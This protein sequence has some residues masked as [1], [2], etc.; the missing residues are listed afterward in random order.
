MS[1]TDRGPSQ[2]ALGAAS[3]RAAH[4]LLDGEPKIL[5]D[6]IVLKLLHPSVLEWIR[7]H[8]DYYQVP[9][10]R[11][12]RT[13][14]MVRSRF[15]EERLE[16]AARA[17]VSQYVILGAG[18]DTFA[19]RQPTWA[20]GLKVFEVDHPASQSAKQELLK[21]AGI[22]QPANLEYVPIDF[23][24]DSLLAGLSRSP[25]L[26]DRPVFFSLL[27]VIVYLT[28][29]AI[30]ALFQAIASL[31]A[32]TEI[33]FSFSSRNPHPGEP[34]RA[35]ITET[36]AA[37]GGEPWITFFQPDALEQDLRGHGFSKIF[38]LTPEETRRRYLQGRSDSLSAS[39][40]ISIVSAR[41]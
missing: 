12:L 34:H 22:P 13:H 2:T 39:P 17:G 27:G 6:P 23:E 3:L 10:R 7:Q 36:Q 29:D 32:Q 24:T 21:D 4:Q 35:T 16:Q 11:S 25:I 18:I 1:L 14:M 15:A 8:P 37:Q 30:D 26:L 28:G 9:R 5:E 40:R 31:P 33:V 41:V 19:Y 20:A 38:F